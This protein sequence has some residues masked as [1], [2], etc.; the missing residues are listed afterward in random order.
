MKVLVLNGS[1]KK[2]SDTMELTKA[3]LK[4]IEGATKAEIEILNIIDMNIKPCRGCFGCWAKKDGKCV[5]AD[6]QNLILEK[7]RKANIVIWSF[8]LYCY[9]FPSHI[10]AV[11]DRMI[12]LVKMDMVEKD[13]EVRHVSNE[14]CKIVDN[15][16]TVVI[17]GAG[18]PNSQGNFD[19][20]QITCDKCFHKAITIFVPETPMMNVPD[21]KPLA[22]MKRA[23]FERAGSELMATGGLKGETV[24][25][26]E[27]LMIPN[28]EY[29]RIVNG[30]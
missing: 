11:L 23:A 20:I 25:E 28:D 24:S 22:D 26:L 2:Q 6:D 10:K 21:A 9:G 8:P 5:I 18:F 29:I 14:S 3:F 1:P 7:Y 15:Q 19:G 4:G 17:V 27:S 13:G 12:P 16:K 30:E